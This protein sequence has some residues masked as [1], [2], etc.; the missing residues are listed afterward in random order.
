M[1]DKTFANGIIFKEPSDKAPDFVV[2]GLSVKKSEF[3]PFLNSQSGD[4]VNLQI[5]LSKAGKPYVE[6]D[7]WKPNKEEPN[8]ETIE[9]VNELE[10]G[11][12]NDGLP[13]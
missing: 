7:T 11:N 5:K 6:L 9:A 4:W 3:I 1:S 13:F 8:K 2:G 10:S 12:G